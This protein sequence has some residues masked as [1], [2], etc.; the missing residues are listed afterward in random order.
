M[1]AISR[2][3]TF[4]SLDLKSK[5]LMF[6]TLFYLGCA[7]I[8]RI[9]PLTKLGPML[10]TYMED[11][12]FTR[13]HSGN[14]TIKNISSAINIISRYTFW[15]SNCLVRAIAAMKM[16][17]R[18]KIESTLY[19]GM[20]KDEKGNLIAHAWLRSGNVF[21]TGAEEKQRFTIVGKFANNVG[22]N[23]EGELIGK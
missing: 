20:A 5:I 4:L 14:A 11:T 9:L 13:N 21:V 6:E 17:E 22:Y 23:N 3:K 18:R 19:L 8:I 12:S 2:V 15:E 1:S 10:G 16:L 7:R